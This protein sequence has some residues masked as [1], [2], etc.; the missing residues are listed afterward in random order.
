M[1]SYLHLAKKTTQVDRLHKKTTQYLQFCSLKS[2]YRKLSFRPKYRD[3][4]AVVVSEP[5]SREIFYEWFKAIND[6]LPDFGRTIAIVRN[7]LGKAVSYRIKFTH[8]GT[9]KFHVGKMIGEDKTSL[10]KENKT[11]KEK[12]KVMCTDERPI[13]IDFDISKGSLMINLK[14]NLFSLY[15]Q[16][17]RF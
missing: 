16:L 10:G 13:K 7:K 5:I 17:C 8:I 1:S 4:W 11:T 3:P 15:G 2:I 6:H 14:Y 9:F 12:V